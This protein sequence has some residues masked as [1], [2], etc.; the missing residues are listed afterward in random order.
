MKHER[1]KPPDYSG[2]RGDLLLRAIWLLQ[3]QADRLEARGE[4]QSH[5]R[6]FCDEASKQAWPC[7]VAA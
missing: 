3:S 5:V 4:D 2:D 6:E 1:I 7:K